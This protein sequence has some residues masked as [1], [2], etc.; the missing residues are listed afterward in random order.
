LCDVTAAEGK[1][2]VRAALPH[3]WGFSQNSLGWLVGKKTSCKWAFARPA[4]YMLPAALG[5]KFD[6]KDVSADDQELTTFVGR[7]QATLC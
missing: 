3:K 1:D 5:S 7:M 4:M 6:D 2:A